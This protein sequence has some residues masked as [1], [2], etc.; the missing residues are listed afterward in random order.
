MQ[1]PPKLQVRVKPGVRPDVRLDQLLVGLVLRYNRRDY[2]ATLL[3]L[4]DARGELVVIG[5]E[6][7]RRYAEDQRRFPMDYRL[8][9]GALD[10][11]AVVGLGGGRDFDARR[12]TALE[13]PLLASMYRTWW[14]KAQNQE[15]AADE[16]AVTCDGSPV[17][18]L[19]TARRV[20][21]P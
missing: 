1:L 20:G 21:I 13:S 3:G 15:V 4:T 12:A 2:Y 6:L 16:T 18:A 10:G 9:L 19:L 8:S 7:E 17:E 14:E 11:I 5:E